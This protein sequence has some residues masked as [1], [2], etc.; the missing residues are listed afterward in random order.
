MNTLII[1]DCHKPQNNGSSVTKSD[2][3]NFRWVKLVVAHP[4]SQFKTF[5]PLEAFSMAETH[6]A[7][8]DCGAEKGGKLEYKYYR[9]RIQKVMIIFIIVT[10][11]ND[12]PSASKGGTRRSTNTIHNCNHSLSTVLHNIL[13]WFK[14]S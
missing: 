13:F 1:S 2:R 7:C 4:E 6:N 10:T 14:P 9:A 8:T 3:F 5:L 11:V 12:G